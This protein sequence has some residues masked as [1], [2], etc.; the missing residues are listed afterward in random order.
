M[1]ILC[2]IK[3]ISI[4]QIKVKKILRLIKNAHTKINVQKTNCMRIS[5]TKINKMYCFMLIFRAP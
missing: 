3:N 4:N 1:M 2:N 5:I